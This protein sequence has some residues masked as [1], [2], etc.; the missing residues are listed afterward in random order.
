M[1][2]SPSP[3]PS[4]GTVWT[5]GVND[6]LD[7][8][9]VSSQFKPQG[10]FHEDFAA[11][12]QASG[13][14]PHPA[15][16]IPEA[17]SALSSA[18]EGATGK[19]S[20][21][22]TDPGSGSPGPEAPAIP[23][24]IAAQSALLDR[25]AMQVLR[26]VLPT[27]L[28]VDVLRFSSCKLDAEMLTLLRAGIT[29]AS[30]VTTLQVDWNPLEYDFDRETAKELVD[31]P[32]LR[33]DDLE[34]NRSK[35]AAERSLRMFADLL[36]AR[37]G[38][39]E[40]GLQAAAAKIVTSK[41]GALSTIAHEP[42]DMDRFAKA[43]CEGFGASTAEAQE[44]FGVIDGPHFGDG[45]GTVSLEQLRDALEQLPVLELDQEL[46]DPVG[47]AFAAFMDSTSVLELISY[48]CCSLGRIE[49]LCIGQ[50]LKTNQ[51]LRALNLWGNNLC[52]RAA[53]AL[54]DVL[55][56]N[57]GLQFLGLG[58]NYVT[59]VGLEHLCKLVGY[60]RIEKAEA[61]PLLKTIKE[62]VK[63]R[64]KR[65]KAPPPVKSDGRGRKRYTPEF[66]MDEVVEQ[67]DPSTGPFWI[68]TRNMILKTLSLE[69]NPVSDVA[70]VL[71][72][73]PWGPPAELILRGAP[74]AK[75][76][77]ARAEDDLKRAAATATAEEASEAPPASPEDEQAE[78]PPVLGLPEGSGWRLV[79]Q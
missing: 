33:I 36:V 41:S 27:A 35:L 46:A 12:C 63:E 14:L 31:S 42:L 24:V 68:W 2:G 70:T 19:G 67:Q 23:A 64:D 29:D 76:I 61:D 15:F 39:I 3:K 4:T 26:L 47:Q 69:H 32:A 7:V 16:R 50:A 13:V 78:A 55:Q 74:C 58:R 37:C 30:T 21:T 43:L 52:D 59:H 5:L 34:W 56:T 20:P 49:A 62:Q 18:G 38:S 66:H 54:G 10:R 65:L 25:A 57:F 72:L 6:H 8:Q 40:A 51:H 73:Q 53:L 22:R 45:D 17:N 44:I 1:R 9:Q 60:A 28:H 48:R 77:A 11:C 71:R 75:E 79:L